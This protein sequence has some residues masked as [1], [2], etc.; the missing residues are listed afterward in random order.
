MKLAE[1]IEREYEMVNEKKKFASK[2]IMSLIDIIKEIETVIENKLKETKPRERNVTSIYRIARKE[3]TTR[4]LTCSVKDIADVSVIASVS[5]ESEHTGILLTS[6]IAHHYKQTK[7]DRRYVLHI[8]NYSKSPD[9]VG[10]YNNG[11]KIQV[12][13]DAGKK[14]GFYMK[15]GSLFLE[16][17]LKGLLGSCGTDMTGGYMHISG[18]T[19]FAG[20]SMRGGL[21]VVEGDVHTHTG[22]AMQGGIIYVKGNN[23]GNLAENMNGGKIIIDGK[24]GGQ[25]GFKMKNGEIYLEGFLDKE[26]DNNGISSFCQGGKIY[27]KGMQVFPPLNETKDEKR[28]RMKWARSKN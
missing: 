20:I 25:I 28:E 12:N 15:S 11:P 23:Y 22:Q 10:I 7:Y 4:N 27:H 26:Q 2:S 24:S 13:G 14:F 3:L 6:L 21:L 16:G 5:L 1:T 19:S 18:N 17:N 9:Y 8:N